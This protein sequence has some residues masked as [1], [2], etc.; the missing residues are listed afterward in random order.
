MTVELSLQASLLGSLLS[1]RNLAIA[2]K[3]DDY[4]QTKRGEGDGEKKRGWEQGTIS[5]IFLNLHLTG[6]KV[7]FTIYTCFIY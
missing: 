5:A 3:F 2:V 7:T 6:F 4:N 1:T